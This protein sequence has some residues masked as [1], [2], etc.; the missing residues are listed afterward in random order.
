[1]EKSKEEQVDYYLKVLKYTKFELP[2]KHP[3]T[4][5]VIG[6]MSIEFR[7]EVSSTVIKLIL[8]FNS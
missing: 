1:M 7:E 2:I 6:Q 4:K 8:K 5:E 3:H